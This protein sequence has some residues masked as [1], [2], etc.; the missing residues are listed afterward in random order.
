MVYDTVDDQILKGMS[1]TKLRGF[2]FG[3]VFL[4]FLGMFF[5]LLT[6]LIGKL[7]HQLNNIKHYVNPFSLQHFGPSQLPTIL[8]S[9]YRR[10]LSAP[11]VL[12]L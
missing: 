12:V 6:A 7:T 9:Y 8:S 1:S 5:A 3:T 10:L 4:I 11:L 2:S